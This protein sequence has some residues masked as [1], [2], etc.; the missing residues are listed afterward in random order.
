MTINKTVTIIDHKP[1]EVDQ[2]PQTA[3]SNSTIKVKQP[4]QMI[5]RLER[6]PRIQH[7]KHTQ[8]EQLNNNKIRQQP[9]LP[10]EGGFNLSPR[11]K[12]L[13]LKRNMKQHA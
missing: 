8:R 12:A 7:T 3:N 11:D 1:Y 10:G 13:Q 9:R 6:T 5:A 2:D 4:I